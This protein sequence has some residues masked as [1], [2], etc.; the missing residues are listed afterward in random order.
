MFKSI[1]KLYLILGLLT[2]SGFFSL[3]APFP[4]FARVYLDIDSPTAKKIPIVIP[5][6]KNQG[7]LTPLWEIRQRPS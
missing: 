3:A 1:I 5:G 2:L 7:T 4:L 6:L